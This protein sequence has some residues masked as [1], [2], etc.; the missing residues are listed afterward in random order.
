MVELIVSLFHIRNARH[1]SIAM[2]CNHLIERNVGAVARIVSPTLAV[3]CPIP[4][5]I[6]ISYDRVSLALPM[7]FPVHLL[8]VL[9]EVDGVAVLLFHQMS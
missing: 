6:P 2:Q 4:I 3:P 1:A 8:P 5:P 9:K 7:L